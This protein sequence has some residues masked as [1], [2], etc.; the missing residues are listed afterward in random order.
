MPVNKVTGQ[1]HGLVPATAAATVVTTATATAA[2]K[3]GASSSFFAMPM[4]PLLTVPPA[5]ADAA[6]MDDLEKYMTLPVE[7][8]LNNLDVLAWWKEGAC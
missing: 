6:T 3:M 5:A 8:N 2:A 1:N 7:A 4:A